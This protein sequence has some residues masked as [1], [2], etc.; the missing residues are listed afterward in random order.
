MGSPLGAESSVVGFRTCSFVPSLPCHEE[1]LLFEKIRV[2]LLPPLFAFFPLCYTSE[3][4]PA[5]A[6]CILHCYLVPF[7]VVSKADFWNNNANNCS[8]YFML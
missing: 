2:L 8:E 6:I 5:A 1:F 4:H 7:V 3:F